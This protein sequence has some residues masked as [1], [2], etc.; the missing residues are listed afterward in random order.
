[1]AVGS[2]GLLG[3][4]GSGLPSGSSGGNPGFLERLDGRGGSAGLGGLGGTRGVA[5]GPCLGSIVGVC[6]AEIEQFINCYR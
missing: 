1:M 3:I 2:S 5:A 4:S 6:T